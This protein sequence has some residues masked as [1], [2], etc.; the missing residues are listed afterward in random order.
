MLLLIFFIQNL[1]GQNNQFTDAKYYWTKKKI[2]DQNDRLKETR[3]IKRLL[4][5]DPTT[6][7]TKCYLRINRY[8]E[9]AKCVKVEYC[10]I[11]RGGCRALREFEKSYKSR[12]PHFLFY[13]LKVVALGNLGMRWKLY[14]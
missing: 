11:T 4:L 13:R 9:N 2:Y 12:F 14:E 8:Y 3:K 6:S 5:F 1:V 7:R 10:T